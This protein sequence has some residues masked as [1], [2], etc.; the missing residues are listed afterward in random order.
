MRCSWLIAFVLLL[1][2]GTVRAHPQFAL[3]TVNRY[4]RLVLLP[5]KLLLDYSLMVGEVPAE[6]LLRAADLDRNGNLS[7]A[8]LQT[9]AEQLRR[10]VEKDVGLHLDGKPLLLTWTLQPFKPK[11][12]T[13]QPNPAPFALEM[14]AE[15]ALPDNRHIHQIVVDDRADLPPVGEVELRIEDSPEIAVLLTSSGNV[16]GS[17]DTAPSTAPPPVA[18]LFRQFGP[19]RSLLS[20]RSVTVRYQRRPEPTP[21]PRLPL[22]YWFGVTALLALLGATFATRKL[23]RH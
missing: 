12:L 3:S 7:A 10:T 6:Q 9:L 18:M 16:K 19:P 21:P 1:S 11:S 8:E 17:T 15:A 20:D 22:S 14:S 4:G 2:A 13:L 5:N 23:L